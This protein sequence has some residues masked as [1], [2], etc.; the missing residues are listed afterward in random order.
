MIANAD[1]LRAQA[2]DNGEIVKGCDVIVSRGRKVAKGTTGQVF[3]IG[4]KGY[5]PTLGLRT[6]DGATHFTAV[7]NCDRA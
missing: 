3:W 7:K 6:A 4:D 5:G 1:A 2:A